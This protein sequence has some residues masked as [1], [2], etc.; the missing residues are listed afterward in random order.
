MAPA[1]PTDPPRSARPAASD[2]PSARQA[3]VGGP[4]L[5]RLGSLR[6]LYRQ[7][8]RCQDAGFEASGELFNAAIELST[9]AALDQRRRDLEQA[10]LE[11]LCGG[12]Q[13]RAAERFL[14]AW[15]LADDQQRASAAAVAHVQMAAGFIRT[16]NG[17]VE[18]TR[19]WLRFF[20]PGLD[21]A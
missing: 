21:Q 7:L 4:N 16:L 8:L 10:G 3:A 5:P 11:L 14:A 12:C 17:I 9:A 18:A 13:Q 2:G 6:R 19:D 15:A 1:A 20:V